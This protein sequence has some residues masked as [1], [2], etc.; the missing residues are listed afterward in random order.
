MPDF[1]AISAVITA[2]KN[3]LDGAVGAAGSLAGDGLE[4]VLGSLGQTEA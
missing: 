1:A 3:L 2:V 4:T